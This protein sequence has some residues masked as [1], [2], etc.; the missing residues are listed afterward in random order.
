LGLEIGIV[1]FIFKRREGLFSLGFNTK[2]GLATNGI[3]S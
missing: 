2:P 1:T 3:L